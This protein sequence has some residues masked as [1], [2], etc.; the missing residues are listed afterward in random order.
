LTVVV[1]TSVWVDYWRGRSTAAPLEHL[2]E[3]DEVLLHPW[4]RAELAL[5][6]L[7][8]AR[9][10]VL[11]DLAALPPVPRVADDDVMTMIQARSLHGR[12][13]GWVDAHLLASS[14]AVGASLWTHDSTLAAAARG[15][16]VA[17]RR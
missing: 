2:L 8:P 3:A 9:G 11:R 7:G 13:L 15:A 6:A 17:W 4:V 10:R 5:G 12:G 14:L 16:G 1:D